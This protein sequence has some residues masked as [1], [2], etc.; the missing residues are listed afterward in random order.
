MSPPERRE[1][2][3]ARLHA[4]IG[5]RRRLLEKLEAEGTFPAHDRQRSNR[6]VALASAGAI[7]IAAAT[8]VP[9]IL[10]SRHGGAAS[11]QPTRQTGEVPISSA[12]RCPDF[13]PP[14]PPDVPIG[15][16]GPIDRFEDGGLL[17]HTFFNLYH[18]RGFSAGPL[19]SQHYELFRKPDPRVRI[20]IG[21][22]ETVEDADAHRYFQASE[23]ALRRSDGFEDLG[24][25]E[26]VIGCQKATRWKYERISHGERLRATRYRFVVKTKLF[27]VAYDVLFEAPA[28]TYDR[29]RASFDLVEHSFRLNPGLLS[30]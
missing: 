13:K 6:V 27:H 9:V 18:P 28:T 20:R 8:I 4:E 15:K 30:G 25:T 11:A 3:I 29:W 5:D 22:R 2:Q 17:G 16:E 12:S 21:W 23:Q 19:Y 7:V 10:L 14:P 24:T 1:Q 26:A